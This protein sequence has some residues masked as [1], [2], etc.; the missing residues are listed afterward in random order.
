MKSK[1]LQLSAFVTTLFYMS[2]VYAKTAL[3]EMVALLSDNKHKEV[4]EKYLYF[5]GPRI[6]VILAAMLIAV[7]LVNLASEIGKDLGGAQL[8][9]S[10]GN[11]GLA[12]TA[13]AAGFAV[14]KVAPGIGKGIKNIG[15]K[16]SQDSSSQSQQQ[17]TPSAGSKDYEGAN[18]QGQDQASAQAPQDVS[19]ASS[20]LTA[21][22]K[23]DNS[24][25]GSAS[26]GENDSAA[27]GA[28]T[29]GAEGSEGG[30]G[31]VGA[32]VTAVTAAAAAAK[33]AANTVQQGAKAATSAVGGSVGGNAQASDD[34]VSVEGGDDASPE[35][36]ANKPEMPGRPPVRN[37]AG[38]GG[39]GGAGGSG[40]GSGSGSG[41]DSDPVKDALR[42]ELAGDTS[43]L[44]EKIE[45]KVAPL[46]QTADLALSEVRKK[47]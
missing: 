44:D 16:M 43:T 26:A 38:S 2:P 7:N 5:D 40:S 17:S 41:G 42:K 12:I 21:D 31:A 37:L 46:R 27:G 4:V 20:A 32:T 39:A 13:G 18:S 45:T 1:I 24:A 28:G 19:G 14:G 22:N 8:G 11:T 29:G 10:V 47:S 25:M 15:K 36:Q 23:Q 35:L 6:W 30:E 33:T 3:E 9:G 34:A